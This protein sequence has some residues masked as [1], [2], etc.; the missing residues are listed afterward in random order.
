MTAILF[1][2][3]LFSMGAIVIGLIVFK[4]LYM[5]IEW[6]FSLINKMVK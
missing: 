6:I 5:F 2:T 1:Y 3:F 4:F